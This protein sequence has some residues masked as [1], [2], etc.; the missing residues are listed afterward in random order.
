MAYIASKLSPTAFNFISRFT[1]G[2]VKY[3]PVVK[4]LL[5]TRE[6]FAGSYIK[7]FQVFLPRILHAHVI[8]KE[9]SVV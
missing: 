3:G 4:C 8:H 6:N 5:L 1:L 9:F 2:C 7:H